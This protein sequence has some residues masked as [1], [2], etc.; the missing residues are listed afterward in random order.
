MTEEEIANQYM[1]E[2]LQNNKMMR[3]SPSGILRNKQ[4]GPISLPNLA[5]KRETIY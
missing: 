3:S 1:Y 5:D 2:H 4:I